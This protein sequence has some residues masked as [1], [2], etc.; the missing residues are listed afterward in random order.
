M[1]D[2]LLTV[3]RLS[4][5]YFNLFS[6]FSS[7]KCYAVNQV[8][9]EIK[10]KET[11]GI[12]GESGS[13]KTSLG[14]AIIRL[15]PMTS[16]NIYFRNS[17]IS[18]LST[19]QFFPYRKKI[20][21]IFQDP[22][23]SLNPNMTLEAILKEPLEIHFKQLTKQQQQK[24]ILELLDQ[25]C[26]PK[27]ALNRYPNEFSGGQRQRIG[28]ARALAVEPELLICDEPVSALD[29]S[30]QAQIINL[31]VDL[32]K[33][34]SLTYLFISHDMAIVRHVSNSVAVMK[35]GCLVE[36]GSADKIYTQ[37]QHPYTKALLASVPEI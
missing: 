4:V 28:I 35:N 6:K 30:I 1:G 27:N 9:F 23:D 7:K 8:S 13:G 24:R 10:E 25:V 11:L 17:L 18:Q 20:Q 22:F 26:L 31:L 14:R 16:G 19:R 5:N 29:V 2:V 33:Q 3:D 34:L 37:P 36:Q 15:A 21:M 12:V 32:Q